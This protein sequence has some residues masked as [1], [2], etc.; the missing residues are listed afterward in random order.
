M[1]EKLSKGMGDGDEKREGFIKKKKKQTRVEGSGGEKN[2]RIGKSTDFIA[3]FVPSF[4]LS[5]LPGG[6]RS[7]V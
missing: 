6:K 4:T 3:L 1:E 5:T 7:P 2:E